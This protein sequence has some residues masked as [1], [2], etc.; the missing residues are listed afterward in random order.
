MFWLVNM[1]NY[2]IFAYTDF[3]NLNLALK[4][5]YREENWSFILELKI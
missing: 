3:V 5:H 1:K 4:L 2:T